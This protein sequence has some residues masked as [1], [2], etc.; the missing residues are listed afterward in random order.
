MLPGL[1]CKVRQRTSKLF[2]PGDLTGTPTIITSLRRLT[3]Y[4]ARLCR[5]SGNGAN[6]SRANCS[7]IAEN[8]N[9]HSDKGTKTPRLDSFVDTIVVVARL[10]SDFDFDIVV[11]AAV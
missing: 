8:V 1:P 9:S 4:V 5:L 3:R 6:G 11:V 2:A 10:G 7:K